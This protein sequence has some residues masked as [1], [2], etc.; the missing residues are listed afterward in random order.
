[1]TTMLFPC[2]CKAYNGGQCYN[3]L[4]GAHRLCESKRMCSKAPTMSKPMPSKSKPTKKQ[5][6]TTVGTRIALA[7]D[8]LDLSIAAAASKVKLSSSFL[9]LVVSDKR[10]L[11][12]QSVLNLSKVL[13]VKASTL[14]TDSQLADLKA[15]QACAN[16]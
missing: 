11:S 10:Q 16:G 6:P 14:L 3:C 2:S 8:K 12:P 15:L 5:P 1:M 4:N 9:S 7:L 13:G